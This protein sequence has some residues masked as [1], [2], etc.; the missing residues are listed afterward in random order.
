VDV[1]D[2]DVERLTLSETHD[3]G[4]LTPAKVQQQRSGQHEDRFVLL[5]VI[6]ER[7]PVPG[8]DVDD[9]ARVV[10]RV[11]PQQFVSPG[12]VCLRCH[13]TLPRCDVT[14]HAS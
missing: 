9:L 5:V 3:P 7:E 14:P 4:V 10:V 11:G 2:S 12:L 8:I 1:T 13:G 6:L